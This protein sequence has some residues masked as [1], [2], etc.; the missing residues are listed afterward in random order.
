MF[1]P[2]GL[3]KQISCPEG[4]DCGLQNCLFQQNSSTYEQNVTG[5]EYNPAFVVNG[6]SD[7]PPPPKRRRLESPEISDENTNQV[8]KPRLVSTTPLEIDAPFTRDS[9][10]VP[11]SSFPHEPP[12]NS[13]VKAK[14]LATTN[15]NGASSRQTNQSS[16]TTKSTQDKSL[17]PLQSQIRPVSPPTTNLRN[18]SILLSQSTETKAVKV[19]QLNPRK[20]QRDPVL[21]AVRVNCLTKL[22]KQIEAANKKFSQLPA[23]TNP[24]VL[25][26]QELIK[27][28]LDDEEAAANANS[29]SDGYKHA[30]L[31]RLNFFKSMA[32]PRWNVWVN[33]EVRKS[34]SAEQQTT[35]ATNTN[36][37]DT[38]LLNPNQEVAIVR[39]LRSG[40]KPGEKYGYVLKRPTEE[41]IAVAR[42]SLTPGKSEQCDR[43]GTHFQVF[44]GRNAEGKFTSKSPCRYHWARAPP[45]KFAGATVYDCCGAAVG[46][47]GCTVSENHVFKVKDAARL[48]TLWQFETTPAPVNGK[49]HKWPVT[50]DCEMC[51]TTK[52][53]ELIRLTAISWPEKNLLLDI[54]VQPFGE[55][56]DLNTRFSG[57][58]QQMY[59]DA[60]KYGTHALS[61]PS[62]SDRSSPQLE[63]VASPLAARQ[64]LFDLIDT[65]TPLIGHA[66]DNDLNACRIIH[67]FVI[68]TV[69]MYPH[70]RGLPA[71]YKLKDLAKKYLNRIIQNNNEAGHD[72]RE[73]SEATGDLVLVKVAE[74]WS[75]YQEKGWHFDGDVL[76]TSS[77]KLTAKV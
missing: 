51:Y 61:P 48:A 41:E 1:R 72:S 58:S 73:D 28:A 38:G 24:I 20:V 12:L 13:A 2:R 60:P 54:L 46:S 47:E 15:A 14:A 9:K 69:F 49:K 35:K 5:Q 66:I 4:S 44:P 40:L 62:Q 57:V 37:V 39:N 26:E 16:I 55:I 43:C 17:I 56:L 29:S 18:S 22:H 77:K 33:E 53:L 65:D 36:K 21:F 59:L 25:S 50:Y 7:S 68:D 71:R 19:E 70:P 74:T 63:R 76:V 64:L 67:P 6:T 27:Q 32:P 8:K 3:F 52:G 75:K 31:G 34:P 23:S 45:A 30:I 11:K 10:T 42:K